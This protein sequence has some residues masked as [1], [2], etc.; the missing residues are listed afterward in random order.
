M[1]I[2]ALEVLPVL[3]QL[4]FDTAAKGGKKTGR[5]RTKPLAFWANAHSGY[6]KTHCLHSTLSTRLSRS[7]KEN[8]QQDTPE[9]Y[10]KTPKKE[11]GTRV[12]LG[13]T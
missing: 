3:R 7:K 10:K 8:R 1:S 2:L 11:V 13:C 12:F 4:A 5:T 9:K 6:I